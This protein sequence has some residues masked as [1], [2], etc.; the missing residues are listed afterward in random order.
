MKFLEKL[1]FWP[2]VS[3]VRRWN[4]CPIA[5]QTTGNTDADA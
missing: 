2:K 5:A 1:M 3:E 4:R